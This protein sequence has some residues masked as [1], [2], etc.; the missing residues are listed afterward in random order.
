MLGQSPCFSKPDRRVRRDWHARN[1]ER[2][3]PLDQIENL[4]Q[5]L[6]GSEAARRRLNAA[7]TNRRSR[8]GLWKRLFG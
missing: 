3:Q 5:R 6:D 8:R 2:D 4:R 7:L 1:R